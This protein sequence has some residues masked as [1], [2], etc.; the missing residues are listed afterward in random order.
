[1]RVTLRAGNAHRVEGVVLSLSCY[2][3]KITMFVKF[4]AI[5]W[6]IN[7]LSNNSIINVRIWK[8]FCTYATHIIVIIYRISF[9]LNQFSARYRFPF[10]I[11][12][13]YRK[14]T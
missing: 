5:S 14:I 6:K 12:R 10:Q 8:F 4:G 1:M 7:I 13:F 3:F 2:T 9:L 11:L